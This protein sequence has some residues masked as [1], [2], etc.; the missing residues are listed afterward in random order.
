MIKIHYTG[1]IMARLA[2]GSVLERLGGYPVCRPAD[3]NLKWASEVAGKQT[4]DPEK[5][6]C[7][8]CLRLIE[9][10]RKMREEE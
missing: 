9:L 5:V 2:D 10:D 8:R 1:Y 4:E 3:P 7:K 6:T